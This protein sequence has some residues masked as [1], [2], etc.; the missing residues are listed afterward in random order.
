VSGR[1][2]LVGAGPGAADL[3]TLRAARL[4]EAA[5]VVVHDR[6]VG[7]DVLALCRPDAE[8]VDVSKRPGGE[9][10][11]QEEINRLL[12]ERARAGFEVVRLKGGDPFVFGRGGE[13]AQ[14]LEAA[15]VSFDVV[16]GVSSALAA[17]AAA[18]LSLTHREL[19]RSITIVTGHAQAL[20]EHDW[21]ALASTDT[22]VVLMGAA[23]I[24][25]IA[26]CLIAA[27]R[28][29][30]TPAVAV[31][32]ATLPSQRDLAAPLGELAE[33]VAEAGLR[34]PLVLVVGAVAALDLRRALALEARA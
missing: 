1:V 10:V 8:L 6:L 28:A 22:L 16:P 5:E 33:A 21:D 15:G 30:D 32:E 19:A 23:T 29:A 12:V 7:P 27:G 3:L 11:A 24:A 17:P 2:Y 26:R 4:L 14:A 20:E 18:G 9:S 31:Q 34:A 13:E 25:E